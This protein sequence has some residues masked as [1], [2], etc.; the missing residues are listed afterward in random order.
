MPAQFLRIAADAVDKVGVLSPLEADPEDVESR[1]RR[2]A[3][4]M[5]DLPAIVEHRDFQPRIAALIARGP[6]DGADLV[7]AEVDFGR[8][9]MWLDRRR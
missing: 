3:A 8:R 5:T 7:R 1:L 4:D 6:N 9:G 2:D